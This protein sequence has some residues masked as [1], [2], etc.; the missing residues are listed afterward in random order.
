MS[1][2]PPFP[3]SS[4]EEVLPYIIKH[5]FQMTLSE[6]TNLCAWALDQDSVGRAA[7]LNFVQAL[8]YIDPSSLGSDPADQNC[9]IC[10]EKYGIV[11][12]ESDTRSSSPL[13]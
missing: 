9:S 2:R 1:N 3:Y 6:F 8:R 12:V 10:L 5:R 4:S 7:I 13:N 11:L